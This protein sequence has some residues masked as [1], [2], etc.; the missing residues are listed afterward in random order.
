MVIDNAAATDTF[1]AQLGED[2]ESQLAPRGAALDA[3]LT[4]IDGA[5]P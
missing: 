1:V 4:H 5:R 2:W 3:T